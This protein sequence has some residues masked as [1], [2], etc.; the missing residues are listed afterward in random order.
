[1]VLV[2]VLGLVQVELSGLLLGVLSVAEIL[3]IAGICAAGLRHPASGSIRLG[4]LNPAHLTLASLGPLAAICV[5][6]FLG[7]EQ[8]VVYSE[9]AKSPRSTLLRA[10]VV[11]L[12]V[13]TVI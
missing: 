7:F 2:A 9:E 1:W 13:A 11:S 6:S 10:T 5:L 4:A 3:V 12:I 8:S